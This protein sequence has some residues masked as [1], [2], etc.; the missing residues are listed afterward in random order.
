MLIKLLTEV[1][2]EETPLI[3]KIE[4]VAFPQFAVSGV[5]DESVTVIAYVALVAV[6][7]AEGVPL[8]TPVEEIARPAGSA[9]L[10]VNV[11]VPDAP[12]MVCADVGV[13]GEP[14]GPVIVVPKK[15]QPVIAAFA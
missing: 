5:G 13:I 2:I 10:A 15:S 14:T 1:F 12:D 6:E 3:L 8:I 9:G 11:N 7:T 4:T